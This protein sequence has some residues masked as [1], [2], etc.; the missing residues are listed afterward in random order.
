VNAKFV[1]GLPQ[2]KQVGLEHAKKNLRRCERWLAE[3]LPYFKKK[4][5]KTLFQYFLF[6][7]KKNSTTL[8]PNF[9]L[10]R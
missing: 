5:F 8:K 9:L 1:L 6:H 10:N 7:L 3:P 4:I 2:T